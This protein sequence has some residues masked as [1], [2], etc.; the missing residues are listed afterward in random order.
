MTFIVLFGFISGIILGIVGGGS[1]IISVPLLIYISKMPPVTAIGIS[2]IA[3]SASALISTTRTILR[4]KLEFRTAIFMMLAS[5]ATSPIGAEVAQNLDPQTLRKAFA[6]VMIYISLLMW[7][8]IHIIKKNIKSNNSKE[9]K[10][11][12]KNIFKIVP[13]GAFVGFCAGLFSITGGVLMVPSMI[14][15]L[16]MSVKKA[17]STSLLVIV[18]TCFAASINYLDIVPLYETVLFTIS[19]VIGILMISKLSMKI[20]RENIQIIFASVTFF[21]AIIIILKEFNIYSTIL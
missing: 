4:E 19:S 7:Y 9:Y 15:L 14:I 11:Y 13:I 5:I 21:L 2:L 20:K 18:V 16:N 8:R 1:S 17:V 6:F 3:S 12:F 10:F